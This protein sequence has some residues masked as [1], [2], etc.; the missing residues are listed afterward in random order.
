[1]GVLIIAIFVNFYEGGKTRKDG[2]K[3]IDSFASIMYS[4]LYFNKVE[5]FQKNI[6]IESIIYAF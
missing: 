5:N 3:N 6:L 4:I 2:A 1:V